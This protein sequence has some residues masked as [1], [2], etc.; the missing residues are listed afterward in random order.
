[1]VFSILN[2]YLSISFFSAHSLSVIATDLIAEQETEL[3]E[4]IFKRLSR[5]TVYG[6]SGNVNTVDIRYDRF[7]PKVYILGIFYM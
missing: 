1:M 2:T 6:G 4:F 7:P 3:R 5:G